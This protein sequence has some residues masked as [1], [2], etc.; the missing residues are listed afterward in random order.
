MS[1]L[2]SL[3]NLAT[4]TRPADDG[5]LGNAKLTWHHTDMMSEED[6]LASFAARPLSF[7]G[8]AMEV[9]TATGCAIV[10]ETAGLVADLYDGRIG[11]L[12][13]VGDGN[14]K[15]R[16]VAVDVAFDADMH[17]T[18]GLVSFRREDHPSLADDSV[19]P[20]LEGV[21]EVIARPGSGG[22]LRSR[23]FVVRA[24]GGRSGAVALVSL[25]ALSNRA[26]RS[27]STN[28]AIV[29]LNANGEKAS[30]VGTAPPTVWTPRL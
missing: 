20:L 15:S 6:I 25:F 26:S 11:R 9:E 22:A 8:S 14:D 19:D 2:D 10:D 24:F 5:L 12:W 30:V 1:G 3:R 7:S 21:K 27:A 23:G 17:Q 4:G 18:R 28:Y 16:E 29:T 13:R